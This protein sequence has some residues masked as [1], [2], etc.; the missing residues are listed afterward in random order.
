MKNFIVLAISSRPFGGP[1]G[2]VKR[3]FGH[4]STRYSPSGG[5]HESTHPSRHG[6]GIHVSWRDRQRVAALHYCYRLLLNA[7]SSLFINT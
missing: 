1:R 6:S 7:L 4:F 5:E 3:L 2:F